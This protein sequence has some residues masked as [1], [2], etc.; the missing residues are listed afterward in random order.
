MS[1]YVRQQD[2][3]YTTKKK[4][5]DYLGRYPDQTLR[6]FA[7]VIVVDDVLRLRQAVLVLQRGVAT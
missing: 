4:S 7:S 3:S 5:F 6:Y 1:H 2:T